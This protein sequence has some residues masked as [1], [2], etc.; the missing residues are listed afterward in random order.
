MSTFISPDTDSL[1][2]HSH[3]SR[4]QALV[5]AQQ[6]KAYSHSHVITSVLPEASSAARQQGPDKQPH[7]K[8]AAN[9]I[10]GWV[11][12]GGVILSAAVI[13]LGLHLLPTQPG[14]ISVQRL[15][16]FPETLA[17]VG[18]G[19]LILRSQAVIAL[20]LLLLI[21]TPVMRVTV[22]IFTFA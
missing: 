7:K 6:S 18:Q 21:A 9:T 3:V 16:N 12:Q 5:Q 22:S 20:G 13:T 14:G 15:L 1:L 17:Q 11:L 2:S 19:L 10:I 4:S 8:P